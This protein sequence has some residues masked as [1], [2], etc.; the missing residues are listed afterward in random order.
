M[1]PK[2]FVPFR[3]DFQ[4]VSAPGPEPASI[5]ALLLPFITDFILKSELFMF[6]MKEYQPNSHAGSYTT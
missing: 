1:E 5:L 3:P 4:K 6:F 2:L